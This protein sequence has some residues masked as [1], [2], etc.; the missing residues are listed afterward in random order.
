MIALY[1]T[2]NVLVGYYDDFDQFYNWLETQ[3]KFRPNKDYSKYI[4]QYKNPNLCTCTVSKF[5]QP[6]I[7]L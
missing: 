3:R 4:V 7:I 2:C 5:L 1:D 6:D